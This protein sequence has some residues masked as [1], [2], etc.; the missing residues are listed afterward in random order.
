LKS[1]RGQTKQVGLMCTDNL[2][3]IITRRGRCISVPSQV[4]VLESWK[5]MGAHELSIFE[6]I[7]GVYPCTCHALP[8]I[9]TNVKW[10]PLHIYCHLYQWLKTRVW[11]GETVYWIFTSRNYN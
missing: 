9:Y 6:E 11:I 3:W 1:C 4:W 7:S 8:H 10:H 2:N 5:K